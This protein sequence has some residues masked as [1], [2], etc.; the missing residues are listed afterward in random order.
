MSNEL[1]P[2]PFCGGTPDVSQTQGMWRVDCVDDT[3]FVI[4]ETRAA[5]PD[6]AIAAWNRRVPAQG[7]GVPVEVIDAINGI[8]SIGQVT[9]DDY[10]VWCE[11]VRII[12]VWLDAQAQEGDSN[13]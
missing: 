3:C 1:L 12:D 7:A 13:A 11:Y 2:C 4:C 5:T 6:L 9:D 8:I 10:D